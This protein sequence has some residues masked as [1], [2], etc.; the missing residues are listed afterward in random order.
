MSEESPRATLYYV[1]D[2]MC[3]WCWAFRPVWQEILQRLPAGLVVRRLLGG[4]APDS[5][6][7]MPESMQRYLQ[8][9]W[10]SIL[11]RVPGTRFNFDFWSRCRPRRST[12]PACRAVIAARRQDPASESG[13]IEAIQ[14]AYYLRALNPSDETVLTG[15]A[16]ELGLD[17]A[18]FGED[19]VAAETQQALLQEIGQARALGGDSFPS[20]FLV[21]DGECRRLQHDYRDPEPLL[22]QVEGFI[23]G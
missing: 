7:P 11:Q 23:D 6:E 19:L 1:H 13:M 21:R 16:G 9:T 22:R 2:P 3:S 4:L 5:D 18:R 20:L 17:S 10:H 12:Y 14:E 8:Q 15:L